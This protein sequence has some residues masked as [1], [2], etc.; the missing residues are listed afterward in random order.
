MSE[1]SDISVEEL[2][3]EGSPTDLTIM[4]Q[5]LSEKA[6]TSSLFW[7][8]IKNTIG[9]F[10]PFTKGAGTGDEIDTQE[11]G[12]DDEEIDEFESQLSFDSSTNEE[13]VSANMKNG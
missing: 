1:L 10:Y 9:N 5:A 2:V 13:M 6:A 7:E 4:M 12:D 3:V 8:R 11:E